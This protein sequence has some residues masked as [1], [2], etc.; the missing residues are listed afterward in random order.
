L[1]EEAVRDQMTFRTRGSP[2]VIFSKILFDL[3][4]NNDIIYSWQEKTG[5]PLRLSL[6]IR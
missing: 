2:K 1:R 5:K 4:S 3:I 6:M